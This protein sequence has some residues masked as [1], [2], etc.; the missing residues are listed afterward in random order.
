MSKNDNTKSKAAET[1]DALTHHVALDAADAKPPTDD[2]RRWA[3]RYGT[4]IEARLAELRRGLV[5]DAA[6]IEK[7]K[8]LR[9]TTLAMSRDAVLAAIERITQAMGGAVTYAFRELQGLS[10]DDLR[11]LLDSIDPTGRPH[12]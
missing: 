5:P 12:T 3:Q 1:L 8:P 2:D 9:A 11:R 7:A 6:P 4:Q 10:D